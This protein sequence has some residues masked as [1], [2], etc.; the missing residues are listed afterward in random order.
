VSYRQIN[1]DAELRKLCEELAVA[2][3]IAFDTE[4]VSEHSYRSEL[5]LIQ[6]A[7]PDLLAIIDPL[8][9]NDVGPFWELIVAP[10]HETIV[11]AGREELNFC[12]SS[13]GKLPNQL[14]DVQIAAGLVGPEYPAGYGALLYRLLGVSLEKG[15]TRTDWRR[16]PLTK[17]QL[18]YALD[19]VRHL[20]GLRDT[21]VERLTEAGRLEWLGEEMQAWQTEVHDYRGREHWRRLPGGNTLNRRSLAVL[22]ELWIWRDSEAK[23]RNHPVRRVLRDDLMIEVAKRRSSDIKHIQAIRGME[24]SDAH[25]IMPDMAQG[26]QRALDVPEAELPQHQKQGTSNQFALLGQFLSTALTSICK[27]KNL[28]ASLVGTASDVRDLISFRLGIE[29][30]EPPFLATGWR[31]QIVGRLIEDLLEGKVTVH[32]ENPLSEDPLRFVPRP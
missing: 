30:T 13:T 12:L 24:R 10:G 31:E 26:I 18:D 1:N 3:W 4:F 17:H 20:R 21:L 32:V 19:D 28:A 25:R 14:F 8:S 6:V 5:C 27:T 22:R 9:I 16:R 7:A 15:E 11:H 29:T 2:P 23:R